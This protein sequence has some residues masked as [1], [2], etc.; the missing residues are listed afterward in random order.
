MERWH[1]IMGHIGKEPL[2]KLQNNV[3]GAVVTDVV[4][5]SPCSTC[6]VSKA[7]EIV[8][9]RP[10]VEFPVDKPLERVGYD[11]IQMSPSYNNHKWLSHF[12]CLLTSMDF[13][14]THAKKSQAQPIVAAFLNLVE[15]QYKLSVRFFRTDGERTLGD[16]FKDATQGKGIRVERSAPDTQA[17]NGATERAGALIVEKARCMRVE[18]KLP[19]DM[20]PE[21][22][23]TAA[24]LNNRTPKRRLGWKTPHEALTGVKPSLSHLHVFGCRA[25]PLNKHIPLTHKLQPR[26]HIGYLLGYESTNIYRI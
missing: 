10:D 22:V 4:D 21:I 26:A 7:K 13:S 8:S 20:W 16:I 3:H 23:Q 24:Y 2:S 18:A 5:Q 12:R 15:R 9:R 14:Y 19:A 25:Y 6:A 1:S 11:L 17:Q